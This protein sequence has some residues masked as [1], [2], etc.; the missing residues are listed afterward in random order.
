MSL[1]CK[2]EK[3][4]SVSFVRLSLFISVTSSSVTILCARFFRSGITVPAVTLPSSCFDLV[5]ILPFFIQAF[6][7]FKLLM[8]WIRFILCDIH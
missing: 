8:G 2:Q 5:F 1:V 3:F 4:I 6:V 7:S